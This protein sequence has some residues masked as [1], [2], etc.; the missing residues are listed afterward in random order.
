MSSS[1]ILLDEKI[2]CVSLYLLAEIAI[3]VFMFVKSLLS[4]A[5]MITSFTFTYQS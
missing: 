5:Q 2:L 4:L 1:E 3:F